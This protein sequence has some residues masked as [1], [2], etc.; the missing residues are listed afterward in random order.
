MLAGFL[1]LLV[2]LLFACIAQML[3]SRA[4][5]HIRHTCE[6]IGIDDSVALVPVVLLRHMHLGVQAGVMPQSI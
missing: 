4:E 6:L 1:D 5:N 2:S 3:S